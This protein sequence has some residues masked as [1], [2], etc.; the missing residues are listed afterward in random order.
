M[1]LISHKFRLFKTLYM[2]NLFWCVMFKR[3][4]SISLT[5]AYRKVLRSLRKTELE[6]C[7]NARNLWSK[8]R[9][10]SSLLYFKELWISRFDLTQNL[11]C[12]LWEGLISSVE[13][14]KQL[15][16]R[17]RSTDKYSLALCLLQSFIYL[18][19]KRLHRE[20]GPKCQ[21]TWPQVSKLNFYIKTL[22]MLC[23]FSA[24]STKQ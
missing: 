4:K 7:T 10:C 2:N 23:L 24:Q 1:F 18:R 15:K 5:K 14:Q 19:D 16:T 20:A 13:I 3:G 22:N 11:Y 6:L 9:I 17:V 12:Y 8:L 21:F